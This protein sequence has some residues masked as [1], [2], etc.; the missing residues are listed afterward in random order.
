MPQPLS[1]YASIPNLSN[2]TIPHL[3]TCTVVSSSLPTTLLTTATTEQLNQRYNAPLDRKHLHRAMESLENP[4]LRQFSTS[5][6]GSYLV[7][8]SDS[9]H[10]Y[11]ID[12]GSSRHR[13]VFPS[14]QPAIHDILHSQ[15]SRSATRNPM[16]R[17]AYNIT[18]W[19]H[20]ASHQQ[21]HM[22]QQGRGSSSYQIQQPPAKRQKTVSILVAIFWGP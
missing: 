17:A 3:T 6:K 16:N 2:S 14:H 8:F 19:L 7:P 5:P 12:Q 11:K 18:K 10:I 9:N 20:Q 15:A 1:K 13:P 22:Q 21:T 4:A